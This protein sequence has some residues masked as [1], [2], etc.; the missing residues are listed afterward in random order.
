MFILS[1][2]EWRRVT[3][4]LLAL[5]SLVIF[6]HA[7][8]PHDHPHEIYGDG[9]FAAVH[10]IFAEKLFVLILP[11]IVFILALQLV[12]PQMIIN[13]S[14]SRGVQ[15]PHVPLLTGLRRVFARG[16]LNTKTH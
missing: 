6:M 14:F 11:A 15:V 16:I 12:R 13:H 9:I 2:Q 5:F 3:I 7:V 10:S 8:I 1:R 4:V